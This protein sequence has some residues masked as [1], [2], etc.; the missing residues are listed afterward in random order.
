MNSFDNIIPDYVGLEIFSRKDSLYFSSRLVMIQ[1][2]EDGNKRM[3]A[4]P[5]DLTDLT[6]ESLARKAVKSISAIF[7]AL[8]N[9]IP[10]VDLDTAETLQILNIEEHEDWI[11]RDE[12]YIPWNGTTH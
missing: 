5:L 11:T 2:M 10:V 7:G 12:E 4:V 8:V 6:A 3:L 9:K 1:T